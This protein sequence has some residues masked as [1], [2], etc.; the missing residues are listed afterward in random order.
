[1][2]PVPRTI[3]IVEDDPLLSESYKSACRLARFGLLEAALPMEVQ[4]LQ[5]YTLDEAI[6]AAG[7]TAALDFVSVDLA[8]APS[9][10][11]LR[12]DQRAHGREAG[13]M[14]VLQRLSQR[15]PIPVT[16]V[17]SGETLLSY[18]TDALQRYGVMHF[19]EKSRFDIEQYEAVVK[20]A[21]LYAQAVD[22]LAN[23]EEDAAPLSSLRD[24]ERYW[25]EALVAAQAAGVM[26]RRFP[27][28]LELRIEAVR[29][30]LTDQTT[31]LP[32]G[33]LTH[34]YLKQLVLLQRWSVLL[35]RVEN[36][37]AFSAAYPSQ[38]DPLLFFLAE[39]VRKATAAY[40]GTFVG[41]LGT[42]IGATPGFVAALNA[43]RADELSRIRAAI[44]AA[45]A[46]DAPLFASSLDRARAPVIPQ[47]TVSCWFSR[48]HQFFDLHDLLNTLGSA[49]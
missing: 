20:A 3:L 1:M 40:A 36:L 32:I 17:V 14:L 29:A 37:A 33:S 11:G 43:A 45:V 46:R 10:Q 16:V 27:T 42:G 15:R 25:A 31:G 28:D 18:A 22:L 49:I 21:L 48:D 26:G 2:N 44:E 38:L 12:S 34:D 13:G 5:A 6:A 47:V 30:R 8:L 19:F 39:T 7:D 35:V 4:I 41:I 23:L 9:E 24:A